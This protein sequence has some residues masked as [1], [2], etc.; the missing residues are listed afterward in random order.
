MPNMF[1]EKNKKRIPKSIEEC[2]KIDPVSNDLWNWCEKVEKYGKIIYWVLGILGLLCAFLIADLENEFDIKIFIFFCIILE[3]IISF[4]YFLFHL[5]AVVIGSLASIVQHTK[6]SADVSLYTYAKEN[7]IDLSADIDEDENSFSK[8]IDVLFD[9]FDAFLEKNNSSNHI[10][11]PI[12]AVDENQINK[13]DNIP[14]DI[15]FYKKSDTNILD[16]KDI[17][18]CF[19]DKKDTFDII[20]CEKTC[21]KCGNVLENDKCVFC[22]IKFDT[23]QHYDDT[24]EL[25]PLKQKSLHPSKSCIYCEEQ[26]PQEDV[27]ENSWKCM[28]CGKYISLEKSECECGFKKKYL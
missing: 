12:E 17:Y 5:V 28:G 19:E 4:I 25:A 14:E 10:T 3:A 13:Y 15:D 27:P 8:K 21:P 6:I 11:R 16:D 2:Y 20:L 22:N 9:K 18:S 7:D 23:A 26:Q 24:E 1:S